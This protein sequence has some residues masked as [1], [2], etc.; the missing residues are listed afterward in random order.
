[1]KATKS[2]AKIEIDG[3]V[4]QDNAAKLL[5]QAGAEVLVAGNFVFTAANPKDVVQRLRIT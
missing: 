3:G 5:I 2:S 1:L 4:N